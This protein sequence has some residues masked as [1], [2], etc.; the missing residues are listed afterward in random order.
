MK[1]FVITGHAKFGP[2]HL[3]G[4]WLNTTMPEPCCM[5]RLTS[6]TDVF[7]FSQDAVNAVQVQYRSS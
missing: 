5:D 4:E 3:S 6:D 2:Q 1:K 7:C